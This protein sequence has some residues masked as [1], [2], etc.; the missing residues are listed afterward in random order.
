MNFDEIYALMEQVISENPK[1]ETHQDD[2]VKEAAT[3]DQDPDYVPGDIDT[4]LAATQK[5]LAVNKGVVDPDER[6]SLIF[7]RVFTPDKLF[8]ERIDL[9]ADKLSRTLMRR[10]ARARS[11]KNVMVGHFNPYTE[12]L[13]VGHPLSAP[14]EEINPLHLLEQQRRVTQMGPGGLPSEDVITSDMQN[15]HPSIF[16]FLDAISGPESS[17]IGVDTRAAWDTKIG[18]DGKIYQRY[19]DA[20]SGLDTWQSPD[21]VV[22]KVVGLAD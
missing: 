15:V 8:A 6:D 5:L 14:I 19:R 1:P 3:V 7:R 20:R 17:R 21:S 9:D 10:L 16:G 11:L 4:I 2:E 13:I 18:A 22:D 12:G